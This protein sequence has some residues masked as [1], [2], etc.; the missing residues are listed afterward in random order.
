VV[1]IGTPS[2][3]RAE[4]AETRIQFVRPDGVAV[5]KVGEVVPGG[6]DGLIAM[7]TDAPTRALHEL[8]EWAVA[9]GLELER[10]E[11]SQPSLE[12]VY[13]ELTGDE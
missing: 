10:L 2:S 9:R 6:E 5:P 11:V 13:L 3:L 7:I 8:T 4:R 12:D 1:R